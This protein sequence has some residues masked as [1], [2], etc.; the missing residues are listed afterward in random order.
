[1]RTR[2]PGPGW[3]PETAE[4][5]SGTAGCA[6][7]GGTCAAISG[8][9]EARSWSSRVVGAGVVATAGAGCAAA[10][11]SGTLIVGATSVNG[12]VSGCA[13]TGGAAGGGGAAC[14]AALAFAHFRIAAPLAI[15]PDSSPPARSD[16]WG[17]GISSTA[18]PPRWPCCATRPTAP[19]EYGGSGDRQ[20][21]D[22]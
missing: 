1:M 2:L 14:C 15:W 6:A 21:V 11:G 3:R 5:M 22:Q 12:F 9:R 20:R 8:G 18:S 7:A 4:V 16:R 10:D 17:D 13:A 19:V